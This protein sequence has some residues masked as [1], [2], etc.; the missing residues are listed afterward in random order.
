MLQHIRNVRWVYADILPDY[1]VGYNTAVLFL[2]LRYVLGECPKMTRKTA[3][4]TV[5]R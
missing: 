4:V 2:S 3:V 5:S 1:L